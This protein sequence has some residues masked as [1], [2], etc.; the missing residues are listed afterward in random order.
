[1]KNN[2]YKDMISQIKPDEELIQSTRFLMKQ[3]CRKGSSQARRR[4]ETLLFQMA[5]MMA[6]LLL[7]IGGGVGFGLMSMSMNLGDTPDLIP[8]ELPQPAVI[9]DNDELPYAA[10]TRRVESHAFPE[11][12][13]EG[14]AGGTAP[15]DGVMVNSD[16]EYGTPSNSHAAP[17]ADAPPFDTP[18]AADL[19]LLQIENMTDEELLDGFFNHT[20]PLA[21][22]LTF[23]DFGVPLLG[24]EGFAYEFNTAGSL[25]EATVLAENKAAGLAQMGIPQQHWAMFIGENDLYYSFRVYG[26]YILEHTPV[27]IEHTLRFI[28]YKDTRLMYDGNEIRALG[29]AQAVTDMLDLLI[30]SGLPHSSNH[31]VIHR[32]LEETDTHFIYTDYQVIAQDG[33]I[34][35]RKFNFE[36]DRSTGEIIGFFD[37]GQSR[38]TTLKQVRS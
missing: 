21:D 14:I 35:L 22:I 38:M 27:F 30:F 9:S 19:S 28:V 33:Y 20:F 15:V 13:T 2:L 6:A 3:G 37:P 25:G 12:V 4:K 36:I 31:R 32:S 29:D 26:A 34:R 1:M 24:D 18:L 16:N 5:P 8:P 10:D 11:E 7:I 23:E 17:I